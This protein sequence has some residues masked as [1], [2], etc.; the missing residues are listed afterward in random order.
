[1]A[2]LGHG[3]VLVQVVNVQNFKTVS[4]IA[5]FL[6]KYATCRCTINDYLKSKLIIFEP[7]NNFPTYSNR[8]IDEMVSF[9]EDEGKFVLCVGI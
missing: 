8:S 2:L 9:P 7:P 4:S 6:K 1:M 3:F 5:V